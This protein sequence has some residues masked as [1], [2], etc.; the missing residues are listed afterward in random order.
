MKQKTKLTILSISV[1]GLLSSGLGLVSTDTRAQ[2]GSGRATRN[3]QTVQRV[4]EAVLRNGNAAGCLFA[5]FFGTV[6]SIKEIRNETAERVTLWKIDEKPFQASEQTIEVP[7]N[8]TVGGDF[9]IPWADDAEQYDRHRMTISV[10]DR[11][12][13][14]HFW[15]SGPNVRFS[16]GREFAGNAPS[17]PG[18]SRSGGDR[19][20]VVSMAG[21]QPF[22]ILAGRRCPQLH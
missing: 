9:W 6:T 5:E 3:E 15:Q 12:D 17:V 14:V 19:T 10:G 4:A 8:S 1:V 13:F 11:R 18:V 20:L 22:F 21:G 16:A 7:A 2:S